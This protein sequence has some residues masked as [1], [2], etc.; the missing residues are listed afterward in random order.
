MLQSYLHKLVWIVGLALVQ[1]LVLNHVH[2]AGY[3][4][5]FI[6][7]YLLLK[8]ESDVSRNSLMMW[9]FL[10][11]LMVDLFSDTP[12]MNASATVCLA[13]LRPFL[14]RLFVPRD[15]VDA[16][17]PSVRTMGLSSFMKYMVACTLVHH[18]VLMTLIFFTFSQPLSL[19]LHVI[20]STLF[21]SCCIMALEWI[22]SYKK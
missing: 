3:A 12:G 15:I 8:I 5:P 6:Y 11:G 20:S 9:G 2:I 7:V 18:L 19:L 17:V 16:L 14:L 13:F 4:T 1:G 22:Y 21:T 10:I